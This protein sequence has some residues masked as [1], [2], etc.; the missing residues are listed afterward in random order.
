MNSNDY[1]EDIASKYHRWARIAGP[2]I[3]GI[4]AN[5]CKIFP[6]DIKYLRN[7]DVPSCVNLS[8][9]PYDSSTKRP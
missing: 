1:L 5:R 2:L 3:K 6:Y 7:H 8:T 4:F 9:V